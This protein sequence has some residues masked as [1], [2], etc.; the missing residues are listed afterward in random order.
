MNIL[1]I[2]MLGNYV[3][4]VD[5]KVVQR[6]HLSI[7]NKA[8]ITT[9]SQ[10]DSTIINVLETDWQHAVVFAR[11]E[12]KNPIYDENGHNIK[13]EMINLTYY[14]DKKK[15]VIQFIYE[16]KKMTDL[17]MNSDYGVYRPFVKERRT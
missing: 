16:N 11:D 9:Y 1:E 17:Y 14:V 7:I 8:K 6:I 4:I 3:F 10:E 5:E 15:H 2:G 12:Y 13:E